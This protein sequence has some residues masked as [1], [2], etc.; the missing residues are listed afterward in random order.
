MSTGLLVK[1]WSEGAGSEK[2]ALV[3]SVDARLAS[4]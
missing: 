2:I 3:F 4:K 1:A